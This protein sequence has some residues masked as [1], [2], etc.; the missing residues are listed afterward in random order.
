M[1]EDQVMISVVELVELHSAT[2]GGDGCHAVCLDVIAVS[3]PAD[4]L[5]ARHL[6]RGRWNLVEGP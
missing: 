4:R 2:K 6:N 3:V 1:I 5:S